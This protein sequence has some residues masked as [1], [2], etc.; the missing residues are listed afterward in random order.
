[1]RCLL[2]CWLLVGALSVSAQFNQVQV[3]V[4]RDQPITSAMVMSVRGSLQVMAD[5]RTVGEVPSTDGLRVERTADGL[6]ARTLDHTWTARARLTIRPRQAD[7]GVRLRTLAP[8]G[9]E[10]VYPGVLD[11]RRENGRLVFI[12]EVPLEAYVAGVVQSEAG[13]DRP[14]EYYKLQAVTCRTY[15]LANLRKHL[16]EGFQLC[17]QVHCQVYHGRA[18]VPEIPVAVEATR[19]MVVVDAD[20]RLIHATFHSNCGGETLNAEDIWSKPEPY[21]RATRDTFCTAQPHASWTRTIPRSDWLDYL[22]N[23]YGM[24]VDD[25][26]VAQELSAHDPLCRGLYLNAWHPLVPLKKVR[27]DWNLRS[28]F[29]VLRTEGDSVVFDGRGFGH[30]VGLCQEGAMEMAR[31]GMPFLD[32]MHHYFAG[33]HLID[34]GALDFFRE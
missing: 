12:N 13:R 18:T 6:T 7:G 1:M 5:G 10:R 16:P 23:T 25:P 19:G 22:R 9:T 2:L 3:A 27:Q 26:L 21:L 24:N 33:V 29:F 14:A 28:T 31:R 30:G 17:D 32:I 8:K 4:L 34:L 15:A 11:V 20:I